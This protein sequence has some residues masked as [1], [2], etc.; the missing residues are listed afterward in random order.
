MIF[1]NDLDNDSIQQ[2]GNDPSLSA[3]LPHHERDPEFE[4][5]PEMLVHGDD[6]EGTI[7]EE[8]AFNDIDHSS[9]IEELQKEGELPIEELFAKYYGNEVDPQ[10]LDIFDNTTVEL[11]DSVHTGEIKRKRTHE[12]MESNKQMWG[13]PAMD[14]SDEMSLKAAEVH[15]G[16]MDLDLNT[17]N[18]D[19]KLGDG[20][21]DEFDPFFNQRITRGLAAL[22]S[23]FF[24]EDYSTDEEYQPAIDNWRKDVQIGK[25]F[26]ADVDENM[27]HYRAGEREN[28]GDKLLWEPDVVPQAQLDSFL[29][30]AYKLDDMNT[31]IE[32]DDEQVL[33]TLL[34]AGD[35]DVALK[36]RQEQVRKGPNV[37][38]WSEE[39]CQNFEQGL[40]VFGKDFRLIQRNKV[41]SRSVGEIVQ[42]YY[43]WKKTERHDAFVQQTKFGRKKYPLPGISD[44]MG[45]FMEENE[46]VFPNR[47]ISPNF[48]SENQTATPANG[49]AYLKD[50]EETT[51]DKCDMSSRDTSSRNIS[52]PIY[53]KEQDSYLNNS[54]SVGFNQESVENTGWNRTSLVPLV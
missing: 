42:F 26:Q 35:V 32:K 25:E 11:K 4:V 49:S 21:D 1:N 48:T 7:D 9:E 2:V 30:V 38:L 37:S 6:N 12:E 45:R 46:S 44:V 43:L 28:D 13:D 47:S 5:T 14:I 51:N 16:H 40:R 15:D 27:S 24:D 22:N 52:Y 36:R 39:E 19:I 50:N 41:K 33:Y 23:Q 53:G 54:H 20:N 10:K 8:E 18:S 31:P 17:S 34:Q 3:P 29:E